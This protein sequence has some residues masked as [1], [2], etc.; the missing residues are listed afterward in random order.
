[1]IDVQGWQS[2]SWKMNQQGKI[3]MTM[4]P[5]DYTESMEGT[6]KFFEDQYQGIVEDIQSE[7]E[8]EVPLPSH[9]YSDSGAGF[10]E[11]FEDILAD[12][13][14]RRFPE[15]LIPPPWSGDFHLHENAIS[16]TKHH[17]Y[18][19]PGFTFIIDGDVEKGW[20]ETPE[21]LDERIQKVVKFLNSNPEK[22]KG[23]R[24]INMNYN[25]RIQMLIDLKGAHLG[26]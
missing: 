10:R 16:M 3:R 23:L 14:L 6:R 15:E 18:N 20:K 25:K 21:M 2:F 9:V 22:Q 7:F 26:R 5:A 19:V 1:M 17:L 24:N 4:L 12:F 8:D 13:N 11:Q